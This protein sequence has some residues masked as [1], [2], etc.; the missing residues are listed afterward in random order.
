MKRKIIVAI[1]V[2]LML[3]VAAYVISEQKMPAVSAASTPESTSAAALAS[4]ANVAQGETNSEESNSEG[5]I[6]VPEKPVGYDSPEYNST[7]QKTKIVSGPN[8]GQTIDW[9]SNDQWETMSSEERGKYLE[10]RDPELYRTAQRA[11]ESDAEYR[12]R[13][14]SYT[15]QEQK[16]DF[17]SILNG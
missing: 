6:T 8:A 17:Q 13:L 11:G 10:M 1:A 4:E 12:A 16:D 3:G 15:S 7:P 2:V 14:S 5:S 9:P